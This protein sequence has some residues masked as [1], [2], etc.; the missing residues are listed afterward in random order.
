MADPSPFSSFL[1]LASLALSNKCTVETFSCHLI[2]RMFQR[3]LLAKVWS[4]GVILAYALSRTAFEM[5]IMLLCESVV[6][7]RMYKAC[8]AFLTG[9]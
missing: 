2:L 3:H 6:G 9:S 8:F 5:Q 1:F 7:R 4:V